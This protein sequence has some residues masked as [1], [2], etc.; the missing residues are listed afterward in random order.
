MVT[1]QEDFNEFVNRI[2]EADVLEWARQQRPDTKW[3]VMNVTNLTVFVNKMTDHPIG[4]PKVELP[5][6]IKNNQTIIGMD[7]HLQLRTPYKDSLCFFRALAIHKGVNYRDS[8]RELTEAVHYYFDMLVGGNPT[9]FDGVTLGDLPDIEKKL[10][11]NINVYKLEEKEGSTVAELVQRSHRAYTEVIN[12]NLFEDHFSLIT[13]MDQYCK[14]YKC[15]LCKGKLFTSC[16]KLHRHEKTCDGATKRDFVG[17]VYRPE[18]TVFELLEDEGVAVPEEERYYPYR[19]VYDFESYFDKENLPDATDKLEWLARH[20][21]LSVSVKSNLPEFTEP[22]WLVTDGDPQ[23]LVQDMVTYML[24]IQE[25]AKVRMNERHQKYYDQL[26]ELTEAR[27]SCEPGAYEEDME[28]DNEE[29]EKKI[30][31]PLDSLKHKY[32]AWMAEIPVIG[33]NSQRNMT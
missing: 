3:V 14:S 26:L 28:V 7:K 13:D 19:I 18:A 17:G 15:R 6:Y 27:K 23:K 31:H 25:A 21:P 5:D 11:M 30:K 2:S 16:K 29:T 22:K 20:E 12:L 9:Q 8:P 24:E 1:N 32:E 4:C 33:F 10:E